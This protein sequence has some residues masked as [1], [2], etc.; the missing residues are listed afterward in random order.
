MRCGFRL[1]GLDGSEVEGGVLIVAADSSGTYLTQVCTRRFLEQANR[2]LRH[3]IIR[4]YFL[5]QEGNGSTLLLTAT[6]EAQVRPC[7][8]Q[9]ILSAKGL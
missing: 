3:P 4:R 8:A 5:L 7:K 2:M 6:L 9:E 1:G